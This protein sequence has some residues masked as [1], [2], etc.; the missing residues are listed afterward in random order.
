M[1]KIINNLLAMEIVEEGEQSKLLNK[2]ITHV[3]SNIKKEKIYKELTRV[4]ED[5]NERLMQDVERQL[6]VK[7]DKDEF[8]NS[9]LSKIAAY[10]IENPDKP[11]I[12]DEVLSEYFQA[13]NKHYYQSKLTQVAEVNQDMLVLNTP[14][15]K[16]I[17]EERK[18]M[19]QMTLGNLKSQFGYCDE[20][21]LASLA[22]MLQHKKK[23]ILK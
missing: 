17:S 10:K 3:T 15:V 8:R 19:A 2:Y 18:K 11:V 20:C 22:Y 1:N 5:L 23:E 6:D 13:L 21:A 16:I 9:V 14:D 7:I 4:Y 12:L